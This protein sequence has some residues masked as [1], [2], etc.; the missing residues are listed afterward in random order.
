MKTTPIKSSMQAS[1]EVAALKSIWSQES[2]LL[3][4]TLIYVAELLEKNARVPKKR[5]VSAWQ[6]FLATEMKAG[7]SIQEAAA[8]WKQRKS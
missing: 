1:K 4:R 6:K 7:A 5:A 2:L 3:L 8:K